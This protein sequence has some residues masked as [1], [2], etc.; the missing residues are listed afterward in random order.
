MSNSN[1]DE[2]KELYKRNREDAHRAHDQQH[3][4][5]EYLNK[6]AMDSGTAALRAL[7]LINGGA[8]AATLAF[9]GGLIGQGRIKVDEHFYDVT[10][11]L[12]WFATGVALAAFA[13]GLAYLTNASAASAAASYQKT[14]VHPYIE[15]TAASKRWNWARVIFQLLAIACALASVLVF[16]G[17]M[18]SVRGAIITL[19]FL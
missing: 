3:V 19:N 12:L 15:G 4:L 1:F 11:S 2:P 17:G 14:W 7:I 13:L 6:G 5:V 16:V 18:W 8:A 9:L 10:R